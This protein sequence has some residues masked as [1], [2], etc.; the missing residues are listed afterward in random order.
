M[1]IRYMRNTAKEKEGT[2]GILSKGN[3]VHKAYYQME[4]RYTSI[5]P[6]GNKVHKAYCQMEI[7]YR[8]HTAKWK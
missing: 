4:I 7:R 3:K 6:N 5:L 8:R 2:Q 1:E